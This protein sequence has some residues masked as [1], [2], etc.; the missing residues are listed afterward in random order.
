MKKKIWLICLFLISLNLAFIVSAIN[1]EVQPEVIRD[2]VIVELNEPALF[3]L[4]IRNL[5]EKDT[6]EIYSLVGVDM[7]FKGTFTLNQGELKKIRINVKADENT[8]KTLGYYNFAYKIKGADTGIQNETLSI[9]ISSLKDALILSAD[10]ISLDDDTTTI[11]IKNKENFIFE[12]VNAE[13]ISTFFDYKELFSLEPFEQ[14]DFVTYLDKEKLKGLVAGPYLL[15][16]NINIG[17]VE[18]TLK[19]TIKFL[20]KSGISTSENREGFIVY[21]EEIEKLNEGNLP[22]LVQIKLTRNIISRLFTT[23]NIV[24]NKVDREGFIVTYVWQEE[25]R[26][27]QSLKVVAKTN[28]FIPVFI[29]IGIIVLIILYKNYL[30]SDLILKKKVR[31]V[32]TKGGEFALKVTLIAKARR[33]VERVTLMDKIPP[34]VKLYERYGAITPNKV[35]EVNRRVEWNL[36]SLDE[37][38]ERAVSYI[39]YSKIGVIGRFE[40]PPARAIYEKE[41]K[42]KETSSNSA[43]FINEPRVRTDEE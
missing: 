42:I 10:S 13:F 43:F 32:K 19:S 7:G 34:V 28:W 35:D 12:D 17:E 9:K 23:F 14:K 2:S 33:F 1:L 22:T 24:P 20:E 15:D 4:N 31:F 39:V 8:K 16:G 40:L 27:L 29:L 3:D 6:F 11:H 41:G 25:L 21:R 38:E 5:G 37:G 26:P 18:E 30:V 36:P